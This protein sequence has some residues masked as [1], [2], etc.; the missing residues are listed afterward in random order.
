MDL[1]AEPTVQCYHTPIISQDGL[2]PTGK[3]SG[4]T[5]EVVVLQP[6]SR[7]WIRLRD[8]DPTSMPLINP[9]FIGH[10][11]DLKVAV[12]GV[13]A[14]RKVMVQESLVS[15]IDEE[16]SL[17]QGF[18]VMKISASGLGRSRRQCGILLAPAAWEAMSRLLWMLI[19]A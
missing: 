3:R 7:G 18:R 9:N 16:V 11:E 8:S 10:E 1:A 5:F 14:I 2:S 17:V 12:E 19:Y 6:K 15:L 13:K 4:V